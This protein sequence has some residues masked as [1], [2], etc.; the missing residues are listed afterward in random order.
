MKFL[1][2]SKKMNLDETIK[3]L[4]NYN[5]WRRSNEFPPQME[6][7]N[8]KLIGEAIDF[9]IEALTE[10]KDLKKYSKTKLNK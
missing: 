3:T 9:A 4:Q 1:Q 10:I 7:P 5:K 2:S 8:P 6:Q